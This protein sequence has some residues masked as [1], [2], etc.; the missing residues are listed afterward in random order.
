MGR[1]HTPGAG[2]SPASYLFPETAHL[3]L[4]ALA[5][6]SSLLSQSLHRVQS[7][8]PLLS[9]QALSSASQIHP[10]FLSCIAASVL[11]VGPSSGFPAAPGS[12]S[13]GTDSGALMES[14]L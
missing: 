12:D 3:T 13:G 5:H 4:E 9:S 11:V 8:F 14:L 1:P 10:S 2:P 7:Q 6:G